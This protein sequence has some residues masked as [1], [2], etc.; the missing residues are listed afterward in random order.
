MLFFF[1]TYLF[2][3][4]MLSRRSST[5]TAIWSVQPRPMKVSVRSLSM[6]LAVPYCKRSQS[7]ARSAVSCKFEVFR[8]G[9]IVPGL[10]TVF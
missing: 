5:Q 1:F 7:M 8:V 9:S 6:P 2:N 10:A 3:R 4:V